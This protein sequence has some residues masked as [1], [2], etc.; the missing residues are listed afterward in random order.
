M[1]K[2]YVTWLQKMYQEYIFLFAMY[3]FMRLH[4]PSLTG[5]SFNSYHIFYQGA[6][7]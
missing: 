5:K 3:S 1:M 2:H 6:G 4:Q 7:F